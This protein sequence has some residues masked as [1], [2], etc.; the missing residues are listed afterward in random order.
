M[1]GGPKSFGLDAS[2]YPGP[3]W[4]SICS[5]GWPPT[6]LPQSQEMATATSVTS[7]QDIVMGY[8]TFLLPQGRRQAVL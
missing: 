7:R 2:L 6:P 5:I 8:I 3:V 4:G 1:P